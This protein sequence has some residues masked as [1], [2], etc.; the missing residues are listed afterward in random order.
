M[1]KNTFTIIEENGNEIEYDILFTFDSDD[2]GKSYIVYTD[3]TRD[4][5]GNVQVF[6]SVENKELSRLEPIETE[7]EWRLIERILETLQEEIRS[8]DLNIKRVTEKIN[9]VP[10]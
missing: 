6:A 8:G 10:F 3:E 2:T 4:A 9:E 1:N 5:N 7:R